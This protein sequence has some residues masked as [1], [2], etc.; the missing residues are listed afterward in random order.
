MNKLFA[1]DMKPFH[2]NVPE[3]ELTELRKDWY[4]KSGRDWHDYNVVLE[5]IIR[6]ECSSYFMTWSHLLVIGKI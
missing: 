1:M 4:D 3:A 2:V 5:G 6:L